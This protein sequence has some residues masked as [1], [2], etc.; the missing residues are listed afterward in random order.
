MNI[1]SWDASVWIPI[2]IALIAAIP[3]F[4]ALSKR[5]SEVELNSAT[6][7][8]KTSEALSRLADRL[9]TVEDELGETR[10]ELE[11]TKTF[12]GITQLQLDGTSA[13]LQSAKKELTKAL[14]RIL[15]LET[16]NHN[17]RNKRRGKQAI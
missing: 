8:E 5:R 14:G 17:L 13:E 15:E 11:K 1:S 10:K 9:K 7:S 2:L 4:V 12:L 6:A 3:G 16:E